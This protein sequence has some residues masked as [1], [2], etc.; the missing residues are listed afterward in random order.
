[1][2]TQLL[3]KIKSHE[4]DC[5][6]CIYELSK[7]RDN[8]GIQFLLVEKL[9]TFQYVDLEFFI[10]QLIQILV[11][12]ESECMALHD[13]ILDFCRKQPHFCLLV[14]WNLQAY[15]FELKNQPDSYSFHIV[16]SFINSLQGIMFNL[17]SFCRELYGFQ[18]CPHR[19][20]TLRYHH[21]VL[22][23]TRG[24]YG[25]GSVPRVGENHGT[26]VVGRRNQKA[27][28]R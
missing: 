11:S 17:I 12:Y 2:S 8:V 10:P 28:V 24:V 9:A 13:L 25:P 22:C 6:E 26:H 5:F 27:G 18:P 23:R 21:F 16:R 7:H 1:M 14:F 4:F 15:V 20:W 3:D 19:F